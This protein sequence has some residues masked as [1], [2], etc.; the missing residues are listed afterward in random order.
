[1]VQRK[2]DQELV[3]SVNN[4]CGLSQRKMGRKFRVHHT[5]ISRNLRKRTINN[6]K[7]ER[8]VYENNRKAQDIDHLV[9]RIKRKAKE[10]DQQILQGMMEGVRKKLRAL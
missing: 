3:E 9:Q 10:L 2:I 6:K 1:M 8:K 5:T 4:R 7:L